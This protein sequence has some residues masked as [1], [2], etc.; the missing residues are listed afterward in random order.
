MRAMLNVGIDQRKSL[1][2]TGASGTCGRYLS[3]HFSSRPDRYLVYT[4]SRRPVENPRHIRHDLLERL[5]MS[6][7]PTSI[8]LLIH[9]AARVE[10][11]EA[12]YSVLDV[13][14]KSTFNAAIYALAARASHF[15]YL[16]SIAIYGAEPVDHMVREIDP[17][18]AVSPYGL[19]KLLGEV[20]CNNMLASRMTH[21]SLRLGYVLAPEVP[22]RYVIRRFGELLARGEPIDLINPDITHF[23]FVDIADVASICESLFAHPV[24][25]TFNVVGDQWP[26]V[27]EV[28]EEVRNHF[29]DSSSPVNELHQP[30]RA[31]AK[32]FDNTR[33]KTAVGVDRFIPFR[34]SL[35]RILK[36]IPVH[37]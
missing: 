3:Q 25:D 15:I 32:Q 7:F 4:T 18:K 6:R 24:S 17:P 19:S 10:E 23:N 14:V 36:E 12:D 2:I 37:D 9:C 34:E 13:N 30:H 16:S 27:R 29:P 20:V 1:L 33:I 8:D 21:S 35:R 11:S 26:S 28:F 5:P 31:Y 22:Q